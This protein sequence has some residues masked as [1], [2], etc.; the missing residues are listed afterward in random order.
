[1]SDKVIDPGVDFLG[2]L[3]Q[4]TDSVAEEIEAFHKSIQHLPQIEQ[5]RAWLARSEARLARVKA[6]D[7]PDFMVADNQRIVDKY[8]A[9]IVELA[10]ARSIV[11]PDIAAENRAEGYC[12]L[13]KEAADQPHLSTC[14]MMTYEPDEGQ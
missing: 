13:C 1:M 12:I 10:K 7:A 14:P 11:P 9:R 4:I 6:M 8:K 5:D 3:E 2:A